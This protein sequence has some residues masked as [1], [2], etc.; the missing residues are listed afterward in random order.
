MLSAPT[1]RWC[2]FSKTATGHYKKEKIQHVH[3]TGHFGSL[4][5]P[6]KLREEGIDFESDENLR[7]M[8]Y[9]NNMPEYL[10][11]C[12]LIITRSGAITLSEIEAQGKAA[13]LIP[14]PNVTENHQYH[15]A[16][17]LERAGAGIV[18]EEKDLSGKKLCDTIEKL[19][20][21]P[22]KLLDM[23]RCAAAKA[24]ADANTLI[25]NEI[26]ALIKNDKK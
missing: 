25:Y 14:S 2:Q 24:K 7:V 5:M 16:M 10:A 1:A 15:N 26:M 21:N 11:A 18:I 4:W 22:Q 3:A 12:D 6:D 13:I 23:G 8:E 9:I 20:Q 17:V 19:T